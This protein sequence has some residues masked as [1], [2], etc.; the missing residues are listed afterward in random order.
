MDAL[1][2][3]VASGWRERESAGERRGGTGALKS[4]RAL[5]ALESTEELESTGEHWRALES[6]G[7][8]WRALEGTGEHWRALESTGEHWLALSHTHI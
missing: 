6:T 4:W 8:H 7:E 1:G 2:S 3:C 5:R